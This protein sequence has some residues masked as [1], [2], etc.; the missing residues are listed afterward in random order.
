ME[1]VIIDKEKC[2]GCKLCI[3]DC[4]RRIISLKNGK[5]NIESSYC[6]EC[7]HCVA[8]CPVNA[9]SMPSYTNDEIME[10]NYEDFKIDPARLLN[11]IKFRRSTR[12]FK[13]TDIEDEK[14][15]LI[16]EAGRFAPTGGN[17]QGNRYIVVKDRIDEIRDIAFKTLYEKAVNEY[18][19]GEWSIYKNK[20]IEIYND[21]IHNKND[22]L[23]YNAPIII[24]IAGQTSPMSTIDSALAASYMELVAGSLGLGVCY[25]GFLNAACEFNPEIKNILEV[26]DNE[27]LKIIFAAG[28]PDVSYKRTVNRKKPSIKIY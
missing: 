24:I 20:W 12:I 23:F 21:Y 3:R 10:Y 5:A 14:I 8:I 1:K 22:R 2:I 6:L 19:M 25:I 15:N 18:D 16:I 17:R 28:Y 11:F 27:D 26:R 9:V 13:P 7:G 4:N